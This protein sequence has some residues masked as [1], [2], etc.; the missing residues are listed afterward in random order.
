[1]NNNIHC[2]SAKAMLMNA[3]YVPFVAF[4]NHFHQQLLILGVFICI[5]FALGFSKALYLRKPILY[6]RLWGG[7]MTKLTTITLPF[8]FYFFV[9]GL[10]EFKVEFDFLLRYVISALIV[11]EFYSVLGHI[12]SFR[13]GKEL[14]DKDLLS[15]VVLK[16]RAFFEAWVIAFRGK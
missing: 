11:I 8:M 5:D 13:T 3:L 6:S 4:L 9:I 16:I 7:V 10:G 12:Y 15:F 1:M 14:E 2:M